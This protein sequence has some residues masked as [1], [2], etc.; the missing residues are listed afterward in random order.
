MEATLRPEYD[1]VRVVTRLQTDPDVARMVARRL[2]ALVEDLGPPGSSSRAALGR[3]TGCGVNHD[4]TRFVVVHESVVLKIEMPPGGPLRDGWDVGPGTSRRDM[5]P[6]MRMAAEVAS[7]LATRAVDLFL[8]ADPDNLRTSML[9]SGEKD[10]RE[11]AG[12]LSAIHCHDNRDTIWSPSP[13]SQA[14]VV[15]GGRIVREL[16]DR[17][18]TIMPRTVLVGIE[19]SMD[20]VGLLL[21]PSSFRSSTMDDMERLRH[22]ADLPEERRRLLENIA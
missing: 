2:G 14:A 4:R 10:A 20:R 7:A 16:D 11:A 1:D 22:I 13:W 17:I 12:D 3:I 8:S 15:R 18:E 21:H 6:Q 5:V 9:F 19:G